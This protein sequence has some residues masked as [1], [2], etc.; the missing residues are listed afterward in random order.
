LA[1]ATAELMRLYG[2]EVR[3][4][5]SGADALKTAEEFN[6]VLILCDMMLPD[7]AGLD[8]AQALRAKCRPRDVLIAMLTAT[9]PDHLREFEREMK[10]PRVNLFLSKPLTNETL[11]GLLS[12]LEVLK[13]R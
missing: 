13:P 6:P 3:V 11:I 7:M 9:S 4:A 8:V 2:L 1:E 12:K 10:P 5:T